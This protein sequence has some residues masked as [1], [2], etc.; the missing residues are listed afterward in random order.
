MKDMGYKTF[1][2][3]I[4]ESYDDIEDDVVRMEKIQSEIKRICNMN[5]NKLHDSYYKMKDILIYNRNNFLSNGTTRVI[6]TLSKYL[7]NNY[8]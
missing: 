6:D 5:K 8:G 2:P 3:F 7:E 4:D 1:E